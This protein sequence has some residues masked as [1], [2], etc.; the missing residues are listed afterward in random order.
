MTDPVSLDHNEYHRKLE[1]REGTQNE[2]VDSILGHANLYRDS[3]CASTIVETMG[4]EINRSVDL[5]CVGIDLDVTSVQN[6]TVNQLF[7]LA[8]YAL[9]L[10]NSTVE[11]LINHHDLKY[12]AGEK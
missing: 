9:D 12:L 10:R 7:T 3:N 6:L 5:M 8:T 11:A 4:Q 1:E 2:L